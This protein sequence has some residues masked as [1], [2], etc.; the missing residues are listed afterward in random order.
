MKTQRGLSLVELMVA[1]TIGSVMI[2]G[3]LF[4]YMKSRDSYAVND[5]VARLQDTA[6]YAISVIEPDVRMSNY[7]GL[8]KGAGVITDQAAQTATSL[9]EPTSCGTNFAHDL[10][11]NLEGDNNSY[12][13]GCAAYGAG[14][15]GSADTLTVRRASAATTVSTAG[16][17]QICST[18]LSARLYSDGGVCTAAPA[19]QVN[20]LIVSTYY[21]SR[22]SEQPNRPGLP[23][24]RRHTLINGPAFQDVEIIPAVED[25]QVQFG[26]DPSGT[27]GV[28]TQY[29]NPGAMP[30]GAQVVSVR[31]WLLVRAENAEVGFVDDRTYEYG[32]RD[33]DNGVTA[34]LN[35]IGAATQAYRPNDGFRRLLVSRTIQLRNALGT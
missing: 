31:L 6:R 16:M 20:N 8:V 13:L 33:D 5:A 27:N 23:A 10:L 9:G 18:R 7:W 2:A 15:V 4:V 3:A 26:I 25:M 24:L 19:G 11:T 21:L 32:D 35:A 34:D 12:G 29:I 17:L 30:A 28:A 22:D 1:L 14:A